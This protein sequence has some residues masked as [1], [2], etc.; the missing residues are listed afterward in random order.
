MGSSITII[1]KANLICKEIQK[2]RNVF[3]VLK[4]LRISNC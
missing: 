1:G 4:K 3:I 2:F